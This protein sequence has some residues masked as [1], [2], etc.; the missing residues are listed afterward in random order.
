MKMITDVE[1]EGLESLLGKRV[2]LYCGVYIYTGDLVGVNASCVKLSNAGIVYETGPY[3]DKAGNFVK[4]WLDYQ[5][6]PNDWYVSTQ[7]IESFGILK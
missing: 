6:L 2:T 7:S 4:D 3:F 5:R 1:G